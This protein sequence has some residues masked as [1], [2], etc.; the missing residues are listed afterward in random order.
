MIYV[1]QAENRYIKIGFAH[2]PH[3]RLFGCLSNSPLQLRLIAVFPGN[4]GDEA[5]LHAQFEGS[6]AHSEWFLPTD[7]ISAFTREIWGTGLDAVTD[8]VT[9]YKAVRD[10]AKEQARVK[11]S[12][13]HKRLWAD[14]AFRQQKLTDYKRW[15]EQRRSERA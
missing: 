11:R 3:R 4:R 10:A 7:E 9:D 6:R 5:K 15:A 13:A 2:D 12:E 1:F 8:W 14:P